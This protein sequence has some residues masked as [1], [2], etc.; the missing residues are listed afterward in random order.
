VRHEHG[1]S[2]VERF[3]AHL[4]GLSGGVEPQFWRVESTKP[5]LKGLTAIRYRDLP[6]AGSFIGF[7]YG[8]SLADHELWQHGKPE[9]SICV[10][11]DDPRWVLAAADLAEKLR[12]D[13]PFQYGDTL[14]FG[15]PIAPDSTMDGFVVL[16]ASVVDAEDAR[17][18][19]GDDHPINLA[20]LYPTYRSERQFIRQHGPEAFR[21]FDW[22]PYDVSRPPAV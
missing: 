10:D 13:C 21:Q 15:E 19:V 17:I 14:N 11:S 6:E 5:G 9:L 7:T 22:D 2:R 3:L 20:G 1:T 12:G 4:D 18:E 16:G 8:L